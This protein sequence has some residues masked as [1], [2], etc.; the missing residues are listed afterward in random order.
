MRHLRFEACKETA[1]ITFIVS[2]S[3]MRFQFKV[4]HFKVAM[5]TDTFALEY[6]K[7]VKM[8]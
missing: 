7:N 5:V 8:R 1:V 4:R 6:L 3:I 2:R